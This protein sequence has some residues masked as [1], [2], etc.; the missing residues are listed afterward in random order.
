M[1][2]PEKKLLDKLLARIN[3]ILE[4]HLGLFGWGWCTT[5][6]RWT[7]NLHDSSDLGYHC[8]DCCNEKE[9]ILELEKTWNSVGPATR[10][11]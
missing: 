5:C 6:H 3:Y 9:A 7:F 10:R 8:W 11:S 1:V 2:F 4:N